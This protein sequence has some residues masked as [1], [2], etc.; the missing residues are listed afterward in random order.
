LFLTKYKVEFLV[1]KDKEKR[2]VVDLVRKCELLCVPFA[3][4]TKST[5]GEFLAKNGCF[6][7]GKPTTW[8]L[9]EVCRMQ[10]YIEFFSR[11]PVIEFDRTGSL[12]YHV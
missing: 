6:P 2:S 7:K 5:K 12:L 8:V 9:M 3:T 10:Q 4:F 11:A 1:K